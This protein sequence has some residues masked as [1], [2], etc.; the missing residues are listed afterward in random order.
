MSGPEV[1]S[2]MTVL[3]FSML[4]RYGIFTAAHPPPPYFNYESVNW[5]GSI[6]KKDL[7]RI[8]HAADR[9]LQGRLDVFDLIDNHVG[10]PPEWNRDPLTGKSAPM[11]FGKTLDYRNKDLVGDIKYLWEPSRHLHL[12]TLAQAYYISNSRKYLFGIRQ[13]LSSWF[14]QCPYLIGPQWT[15]SL[16]LGVRLIN[17]YL[18]W[19]LIGGLDSELFKG[20]EGESFRDRWLRGIYQHVHYIRGHY[21][22]YSSANNH[23][24]GETASVFI[25]T[26]GWP[27]WPQFKRWQKSSAEQ[28]EHEISLQNTPDGVNREQAIAYQQFVLDFMLL[29]ELTAH[30][31]H[32]VFSPAFKKTIERMLEFIASIMDVDGH[33]PMIGDA[34]DG[35]VVRLSHEDE[36]CP[37]RSLLATGGSDV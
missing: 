35:F 21:S 7:P 19:Q 18:T 17:W 37:Y 31:N 10:H 5:F 11:V 23:I 1:F 36:W 16:E 33:L 27:F 4:E 13:Q 12:V 8:R 34:D 9:I 15:S 6:E 30:A 29:S 28:L 25:A 14:D 24:I 2:R 20:Q 32:A 3:I 22:R 26:T